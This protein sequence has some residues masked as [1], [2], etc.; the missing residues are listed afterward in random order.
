MNTTDTTQEIQVVA[1][2][3]VVVLGAGY[4]GA[5]AAN[6]LRRNPAVAVTVVNPQPFFVQRIRLHQ[7]V[8]GTG[9]PLVGFDDVLADDIRVVVDTATRIDAGARRVHLASG[10][11]LDYDH[12][13]YAIGT[14]HRTP[15][16]PG[17]EHAL[18]IADWASAQR[19]RERVEGLGAHEMITVVG[20]GLTGIEVA[21]E[22][23]ERGH[24]VRLVGGRGI[25]S[26]VGERARSATEKQLIRLGVD[27]VDTGRVVEIGE[28]TVTVDIDGERNVLPSAATIL[29]TGFEAPELAADSGLATDE[30]GRLR[31][32]ATLAGIDDD[33][34]VGAGDAVAVEGM[35]LRMSC[36][37]AEPLGAQAAEAV[38][39]RIAG[40][41]PNPVDQGFVAQCASIGRRA[42]TLQFTRRD[43]SPARA[44]VTGRL[45]AWTKELVCRGTVWN[46]RH[47]ATHP[48]AFRWFRGGDLTTTTEPALR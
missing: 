37:A 36:Q 27:V 16:I 2:T 23:A 9:D 8:S 44:V 18:F 19:I 40:E 25:A 29:A 6:R 13:I 21:A 35:P 11:H 47:E 26:S 45:A 48:G 14:R 43:D 12:L 33:R 34:I 24:A 3:H 17:A 30:I 31:T 41:Q 5:M 7:F 10:A 22:L 38:L 46:I 28:R 4:A 39:A 15:E 1:R 32:D 20:G 42:A